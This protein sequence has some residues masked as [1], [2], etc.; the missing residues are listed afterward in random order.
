MESTE[1]H[2]P[3]LRQVFRYSA[4]LGSATSLWTGS[5]VMGP[6]SELKIGILQ[7]I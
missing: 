2:A 3:L 4:D 1:P 6:K 7:Y 5:S